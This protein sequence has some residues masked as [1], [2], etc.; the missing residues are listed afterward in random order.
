MAVNP[1]RRDADTENRMRY[2]MDV[3]AVWGGESDEKG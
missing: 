1:S 3:L 2:S